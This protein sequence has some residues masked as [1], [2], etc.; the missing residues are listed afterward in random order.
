MRAARKERG[1][2]V[3]RADKNGEMRPKK[4]IAH[5]IMVQ[6][7]Y[8]VLIVFL[9]VAVVTILMIRNEIFST[10]KTELRL[11]SESAVHELNGFFE[12]Y[13]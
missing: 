5:E 1:G 11:E 4:K 6:I 2:A 7:G 13:V 10:K 3:M 8:S 9:A 12:Q